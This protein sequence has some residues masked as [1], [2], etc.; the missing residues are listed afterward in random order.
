MSCKK[1]HKNK[2]QI[3]VQSINL[4]SSNP[5]LQI[6]GLF[7]DINEKLK[8]VVFACLVASN[9]MDLTIILESITH[10]IMRNIR[11]ESINL[12]SVCKISDGTC[13]YFTDSS[14]NSRLYGR[15]RDHH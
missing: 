13:R 5:I 4:L 3:W 7:S 15:G 2:L 1:T 12:H 9:G 11:V 10:K 8:S 6:P 14:E